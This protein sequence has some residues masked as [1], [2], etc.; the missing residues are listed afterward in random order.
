VIVLLLLKRWFVPHHFLQL[1]V[2]V[3]I[4]LGVYSIGVAWAAW[5]KKIWN[6]EGLSCDERDAESTVELVET[7]SQE[8]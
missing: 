4:G 8:A 6:V 1:M 7:S 3:T 5:K 2:Q